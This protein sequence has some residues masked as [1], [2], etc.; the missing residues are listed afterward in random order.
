MSRIKPYYGTS[1]ARLS[2]LVRSS[3]PTPLPSSVQF[4]FGLPKLSDIPVDGATETTA[5][6]V[7]NG[8]VIESTLINWRRLSLSALTRL[9]AQEI[10]EVPYRPFPFSIHDILPEINEALGL[11]LL[12]SEV[13]NHTFTRRHDTW[14]HLYPLAIKEAA[15]YAWYSSVY[16]F[17]MVNP[18]L[19]LA[20][21]FADPDLD[22]LEFTHS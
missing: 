11:S 9:P 12:P 8:V 10:L 7:V 4:Q 18:D 2:A 6:I 3:Q 14:P 22:G 21:L 15:S 1:E 20:V 17:K 16:F 13:E 19:D 5:N